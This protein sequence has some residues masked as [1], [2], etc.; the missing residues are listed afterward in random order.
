M[1]LRE[2]FEAINK[3]IPFKK[4]KSV[5]TPAFT[6]DGRLIKFTKGY[7]SVT[8]Y[9]DG[10]EAGNMQLDCSY[11]LGSYD[12]SFYVQRLWV[13]EEFR[14]QGVATAMYDYAFRAGF[15]PLKQSK[16][17]TD[18]GKGVWNKHLQQ[19]QS[20]GLAQDYHSDYP[21]RFHWRPLLKDNK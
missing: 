19:K 17:L 15:R 9:V 4:P 3:E 21:N 10:K 5:K 12:D 20:L 1:K 16:T 7:T 13:N 6:K 14:G 8:A 11:R 2:L 18:G